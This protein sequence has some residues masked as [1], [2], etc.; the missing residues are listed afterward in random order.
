MHAPLVLVSWL[1]TVQ[2]PGVAWFMGIDWVDP[3]WLLERFGTEFIWISLL[4]LFVECGLFFPFLPGDALLFA[5]GIFI[6]TGQLDVFPGPPLVEL[7]I[8]MLLLIAAAFGGN[9]AGYE[10][11]RRIGP[12]IY[13]REGRLFKRKYIEETEAFFDK[14]G[15]K[16]LVLGRFVAF[17]R[18][19]ITVVAGVTG[20]DRRR[21]YLWSLVG[22]VA[23]VASITM[24]G[25]FL[26]KRVPWLGDNID[27]VIIAI[28]VFGGLL[29]LAEGIRR[30]RTTAPEADDRDHDGRPDRDI[31]GFAVPPRVAD[32]GKPTGGD[33]SEAS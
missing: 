32:E 7:F 26:G 18:T 22:A 30:K 19:Y 23:W 28:F 3:E 2:I 31:A 11:G 1:T 14:H 17:V 29:M 9:V 10:I 24:L 20:M 15:N 33:T 21:F 13:R 6:A 8:G 12:A 16:A 4:I 25:Y 27:Y 5:F